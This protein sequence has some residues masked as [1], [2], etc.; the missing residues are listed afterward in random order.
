[1]KSDKNLEDK[2]FYFEESRRQ[3]DIELNNKFNGE[4]IFM[5]KYHLRRTPITD[6]FKKM[7]CYDCSGYNFRCPYYL[8]NKDA[9]FERR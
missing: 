1:M 3:R 7:G 9:G 6:N 2:C 8:S 4:D 5:M